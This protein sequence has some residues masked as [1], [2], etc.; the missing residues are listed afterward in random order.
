MTAPPSPPS[1]ERLRLDAD[2]LNDFLG[3]AFPHS[4]PASRGRVTEVE[5]GRV[6][7]ALGSEARMLRPGGVLSGPTMMGLADSAVYALV[8]AHIGEVPM[9][10]TSSLTIHFLRPAIATGMLHAEARLLRLG[11]RIATAEVRMWT[12]SPD[13]PC[14]HATLAYAIPDGVT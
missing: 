9:A 6:V 8:L 4:D 12:E 11:R 10:V 1:A 3:R 14:A 7:M 13:R 2:Q 5:P